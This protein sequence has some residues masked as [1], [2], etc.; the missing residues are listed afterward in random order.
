[1]WNDIARK[2][3]ILAYNLSILDFKYKASTNI[4]FFYYAYNLSILDFKS[5]LHRL[6]ADSCTAYNLSILDFK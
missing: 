1:M 6:V 5:K 2:S 4:F 3:R